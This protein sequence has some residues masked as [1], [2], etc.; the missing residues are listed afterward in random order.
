MSAGIAG[1]QGLW[2]LALLIPAAFFCL[3]AAA[4][5]STPAEALYVLDRLA[6]GPRPGDVARVAAMGVDAYIDEQLHPDAL[7]LPDGLE[8]QLAALDTLTLTPRQLFLRYAPSQLQRGAKPT[9]E[10]LQAAQQRARSVVEQTAT[11]RLTRAV[12]S[13]RQLQ[14]VMVTSGSAISTCSPARGWT[15]SGSATTKRRRSGPMR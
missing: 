7:P 14:E 1:R 4:A 5:P 10:E 11:A 8:R 2:K 13:P 15:A 6:F 9:A 12:E 3:P